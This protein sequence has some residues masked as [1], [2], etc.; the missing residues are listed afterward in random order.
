MAIEVR[1]I[2]PLLQVFD[3]P[4]AVKFY[5][6]VVGF[7]VVMTDG[8]PAPNCDWILL[9]MQ[10]FEL[11]LNTAYEGPARQRPCRRAP[12]LTTIAACFS[13]VRTWTARIDISAKRGW[14]SESR[15]WLRTG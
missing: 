4:T 7:E 2:V 11:M 14:S 1:G 6:D 8:K 12:Q 15:K 10:G 3:M 5:C 9:R 13:A